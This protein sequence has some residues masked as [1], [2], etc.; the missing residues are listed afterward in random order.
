[1]RLLPWEYLFTRFDTHAF[2]DLYTSTWVATLGLLVA[3]VI[4][5]N[6]RTRALHRHAP[7]LDMYEWLLWTGISLFGLVL[8]AAV[9]NFY[10]IVLLVILVTGL[11]AL[12]WVRFVRFPP[13]FEVYEQKLAK[14]RY[15]TRSKF[16]HPESTI[17][18]KTV[19]AAK[20]G[21]AKAS[22]QRS[23]ASRSRKRR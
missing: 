6:V 20:V 8:V 15:F 4:L 3:L 10:L 1:M 7:Y 2:P 17:R 11:A 16:A 14:Q 21:A 22:A 19:K 5:Y 12:L 23:R 18:P 13:M 9:F